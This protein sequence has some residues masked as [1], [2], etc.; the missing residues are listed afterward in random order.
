MSSSET[1]TD[2]VYRRVRDDILG[3]V[4]EPGSQLLFN[5]LKAT[6]GA[7]VGVLREALMRLSA[8]GLTVNQAQQGFKVMTVSLDDLVD[9]T[10]TRCVIESLVLE[11]SVTNGDVE[12]ESQI[13]AAHHRMERTVKHDPNDG[14]PVAA[15]WAQAHHLFHMALLSAAKSRR[16]QAIASSLRAAAEVYR[17]W[18]MP[19]E[20]EERDVSGEHQQLV[21]L[22]LKRDAVGAARALTEHLQMTKELILAGSKGVRQ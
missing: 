1:R 14:A 7:S 16:M 6:Y 13:V 5:K 9:L 10:D 19:F 4:I 21:T 22:C 20:V 11:D 8:E 18:S 12:W 17:H 15:A 3:G 2:E